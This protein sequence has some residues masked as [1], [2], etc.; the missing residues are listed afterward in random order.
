MLIITSSWLIL[1]SI[2]VTSVVIALICSWWYIFLYSYPKVQSPLSLS[3]SYMFVIFISSHYT[4]ISIDYMS[5]NNIKRQQSVAINKSK[6]DY[7][8]PFMLF[9]SVLLRLCLLKYSMQVIVLKQINT[10]F[11]PH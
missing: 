7:V 6:V 1:H 3:I 5:L 2:L 10:P 8:N 9:H 4:Q 11:S